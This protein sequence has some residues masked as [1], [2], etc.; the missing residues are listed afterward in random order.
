MTQLDN[1]LTF[2]IV[3]A[4]EGPGWAKVKSQIS[5][6]KSPCEGLLGVRYK[7]GDDPR[8]GR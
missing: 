3:C 1:D 4:P 7:I 6:L 2:A 8:K 5:N